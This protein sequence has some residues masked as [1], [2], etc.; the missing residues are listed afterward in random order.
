MESTNILKF[1]YRL[2]TALFYCFFDKQLWCFGQMAGFTW[3]N[4]ATIAAFGMA[5]INTF[6]R[7]YRTVKEFIF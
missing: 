3:S 2:R 6:L 1:K 4:W 5:K 7:D